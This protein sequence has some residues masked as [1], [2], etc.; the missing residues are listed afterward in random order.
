MFVNCLQECGITMKECKNHYC[1]AHFSYS[2]PKYKEKPKGGPGKH[3]AKEKN[4]IPKMDN[5]Y[6][7]EVE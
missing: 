5:F 1:S 3:T 7:G 6:F 4:V 2:P